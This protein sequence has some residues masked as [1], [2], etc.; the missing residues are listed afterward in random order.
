MWNNQ[1]VNDVNCVF[2]FEKTLLERKKKW[3]AELQR[4]DE[5][6]EELRRSSQQEQEKLWAQLRKARSSTEHS[7]SDQVHTHTHTQSHDQETILPGQDSVGL[8]CCRQTCRGKERWSPRQ[9]L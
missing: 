7:V 4:R 2:L 5:E 6:M 3:Q 8:T 9:P 1:V